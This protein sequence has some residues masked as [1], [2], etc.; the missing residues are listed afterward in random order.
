MSVLGYIQKDVFRCKAGETPEPCCILLQEVHV[1]AFH[2][3]LDNDWVRKHFTITPVTP[4]KWPNRSVY[5]NV[6]LVSR[7]IPVSQAW[8]LEFGG[9][10]MSRNAF[11]VDLKLDVPEHGTPPVT[12]RVANTHL[13]SL[14]RGAGSR[15]LQMSLIAKLLKESGLHGGIVG[16]DMNAIGPSDIPIVANVGLVDAWQGDD[17]DED[18]YTWGYQP[19]DRQFPPGRLDKILMTPGRRMEV[20]EPRKVGVGVKTV[21]GAWTSDHFGLLTRV[22]MLSI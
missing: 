20:E 16:G 21:D 14:P 18:G 7:S 10:E 1:R 13:E 9:S 15:P 12:L 19:P 3:I 4:E 17:E 2:V 5:G 22:S 8:S 6:T 11:L